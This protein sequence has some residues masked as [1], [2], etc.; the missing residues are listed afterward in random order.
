[1]SIRLAAP[2]H[3]AADDPP[4]SRRRSVFSSTASTSST[5]SATRAR[6]VRRRAIPPL[7]A[8]ARR[9]LTRRAPFPTPSPNHTQTP[10]LTRP[11]STSRSRS[12][13]TS[14]SS[15]LPSCLPLLSLACRLTT[16]K[17]FPVARLDPR[18][19]PGACVI[20]WYWYSEAAN[21]QTFESCIVRPLPL[22]LVRLLDRASDTRRP[23][24]PRGRARECRTSSSHTAARRPRRP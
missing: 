10:H 23:L 6:T 9:T 12:S 3:S 24:P 2:R 13:P 1:M 11:R 16:S 21:N 7:T 22:A 19:I 17:T 8:G 20:Q 14:A 15:V 5:T 4:A 18:Q